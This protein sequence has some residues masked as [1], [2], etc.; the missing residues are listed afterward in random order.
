MVTKTPSIGL[1]DKNAPYASPQDIALKQQHFAD[2]VAIYTATLSDEEDRKNFYNFMLAMDNAHKPHLYIPPK[3]TAEHER[4]GQY[5]INA[6]RKFIVDASNLAGGSFRSANGNVIVDRNIRFSP[7]FDITRKADKKM[8]MEDAQLIAW[9]AA[10]R[11]NWVR[12][13]KLKITGTT[14][15]QR[16]IEL[17]ILEQNKF[18]PPEQRL[19]ISNQSGIK[20]ELTS[21]FNR[22]E[23]PDFSAFLGRQ[24][25]GTPVPQQIIPSNHSI[26]DEYP[27]PE[28][29][30]NPAPVIPA[31]LIRDKEQMQQHIE[32]S[33]DE[34]SMLA[35]EKALN[36]SFDE[37]PKK[38]S[39]TL[40]SRLSEENK[41]LIDDLEQLMDKHVERFKEDRFKFSH[42][43]GAGAVHPTVYKYDQPQKNPEDQTGAIYYTVRKNK[44]TIIKLDK[45]DLSMIDDKKFMGDD[46]NHPAHPEFKPLKMPQCEPL[47]TFMRQ[48]ITSSK[49]ELATKFTAA[50]HNAP[51]ENDTQKVIVASSSIGKTA[52]WNVAG[53]SLPVEVLGV[54]H[55]E[56]G[57][58]VKI[59]IENEGLKAVMFDEM[60]FDEIKKSHK[61]SNNI[62]G[63][64]GPSMP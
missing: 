27:E 34:N 4:A 47:S 50:H 11:D 55:D 51:Y 3:N 45:S 49:S 18:L 54:A 52:L 8:T 19:F 22:F 56:K 10:Q 33:L 25:I 62:P 2:S 32:S 58:R 53:S 43:G 6:A 61:I 31:W 35:L 17:A 64:T 38:P 30:N 12:P 20:G 16:M 46:V 28:R 5:F 44:V 63:R 15:E 41:K 21:L 57:V 26:V 14:R 29:I 42:L 1:A 59:R 9:Q 13:A 37:E 40:K 48:E 24:A 23:K 7:E 36:E 39:T 60:N